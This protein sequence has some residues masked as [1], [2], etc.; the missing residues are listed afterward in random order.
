M[1]LASRSNVNKLVRDIRNRWKQRTLLQGGAALLLTFIVFAFLALIFHALL[2]LPSS[3]IRY[4]IGIAALVSLGVAFRYL[5]QPLLNPPEDAQIALLV[6]ERFPELEDRLN[7]AVEARAVAATDPQTEAL[8]EKLIED[9]AGKAQVL[10]LTHVIDR[11]RQ[12]ILM[13]GALTALAVLMLFG[14]TRMDDL[15]LNFAGVAMGLPTLAS[16]PFMT[17][18]PG[19]VEIEKGADQDV[20]VTFRENIDQDVTLHYRNG[21]GEWQKEDMRHGLDG[22]AFQKAFLD[23]Q[24][25]V[26]YYVTYGQD[27]SDSFTINLYT[28]PRVEQIDLRFTYPGYTRRA[29]RTEEDTGDIRGLKGSTVTITVATNGTSEKAELILD[30]ERRIPMRALND[31]RFQTDLPLEEDGFYTIELTDQAG[32]KQQISRRIPHYRTR[33]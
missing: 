1:P 2:Q 33:R 20:V 13:Y 15:R 17:V 24:E 28:F 21:D 26:Q 25:P 6:E 30:E 22:L 27:R 9:A 32:K 29:A 31:G 12:R 4:E 7:S 18:A 8:I 14:Y 16:Q 23:I 19:D 3:W 5:V 11:K 10:P